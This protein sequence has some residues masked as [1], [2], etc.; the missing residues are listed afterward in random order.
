MD[1]VELA[2]RMG[3]A[4]CLIYMV[5]VE[6]M[7]ARIGVCLQSTLKVL[8]VLAGMFALAIFRVCEPYCGRGSF[9]SRPV[10]ACYEVDISIFAKKRRAG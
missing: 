8:Q 10:I 1:L 9:A 4:G 3:P 5:A 6:V 2:S 7:E